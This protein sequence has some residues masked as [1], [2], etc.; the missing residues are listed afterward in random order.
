MK[1]L[2]I[3]NKSVKR[4]ALLKMA[5]KVPGAWIGLRIAAILLILE[6]WKSS[7]VAKL[8]GVTRWSAVQWIQKANSQGLSGLEEGERSGRPSR[9][10]SKIQKELEE[11]LQKSPKDYGLKRNHWDGIVVT[12]YI[13]KTQGVH[14]EV[15]QAQRWI[16]RLGFSLRQPVYQYVQATKEGVARYRNNLKKTP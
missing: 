1:A 14:I 11:A 7:Q 9:I 15:R 16:R 12:E 13:E 2:T 3:T 6:G 10:N 8:F 4:A 5:E